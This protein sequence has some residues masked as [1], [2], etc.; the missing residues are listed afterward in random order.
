MPTRVAP[1][2]ASAQGNS[3]G[4]KQSRLA[5]GTRVPKATLIKAGRK[6]R[7]G[8]EVVV[9]RQTAD[10]RRGPRGLYRAPSAIRRPRDGWALSQA[11]GMPPHADTASTCIVP[12]E[13]L[14]GHESLGLACHPPTRRWATWDGRW[15]VETWAI[16]G[17][18][19]SGQ[20]ADTTDWLPGERRGG[21]VQRKRGS[22]HRTHTTGGLVVGP[23]ALCWTAGMSRD[24]GW[25]RRSAGAG[26]SRRGGRA[27]PPGR[28]N[29][30]GRCVRGLDSMRRRSKSKEKRAVAGHSTERNSSSAGREPT[31]PRGHWLGSRCVRPAVRCRRARIGR[32]AGEACG[33]GCGGCGRAG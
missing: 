10:G 21:G 24:R 30:T 15:Q 32:Q 29:T 8:D 28:T 18:R 6:A 33:C 27:T 17:R 3:R 13:A 16:H 7:E 22:T 4:Q 20:S 12:T 14:I 5:G 25:T 23:L 26:A 11:C 9:W 2:V 19:P 31:T 1:S